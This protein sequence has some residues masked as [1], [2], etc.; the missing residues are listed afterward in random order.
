MS[1]TL[2]KIE[3]MKEEL[4]SLEKQSVSELY[5]KRNKL[6]ESIAAL[7]SEIAAITGKK[8]EKRGPRRTTKEVVSAES[9]R[10][11]LERAPEKTVDIRKAKL[12]LATIKGHAK[13]HPNQFAIVSKGP[14]PLVRLIG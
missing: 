11:I 3:A 14:W 12:D 5:V 8:A 10:S 13:A 2:T 7:D 4:K 6:V 9:L 1:D